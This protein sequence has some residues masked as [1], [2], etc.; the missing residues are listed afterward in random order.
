MVAPIPNPCSP[1]HPTTMKNPKASSSGKGSSQKAPSSSGAAAAPPPPPATANLG[2]APGP[3]SAAAAAAATPNPKEKPAAPTHVSGNLR[4][5]HSAGPPSTSPTPPPSRRPRLRTASTTSSAAPSCS[6][7]AASAPTSPSR[8]IRR[9][10]PPP[11]PPPI[12]CSPTAPN[13]PPRLRPRPGARRGVRVRPALSPPPGGRFSPEDHLRD[14][15]FGRGSG[16]QND[17]WAS[18]GLDG[19]RG[20]SESGP[21]SLKRKYGEDDELAWSRRHVLLYGGAGGNPPGLPPGWA[22]SEMISV[23]LDV[24]KQAL[25]RAF[26]KF[27]KTINESF[28]QKK[29][30]LENGK[31]EPLKCIACG[32][33]AYVWKFSFY[34]TTA[35]AM[36]A[37]GGA[38]PTLDGALVD[39]DG[40]LGTFGAMVAASTEAVKLIMP[41][42]LLIDSCFYGSCKANYAC[43]S[44]DWASK[45]FADVHALIM[46][47]YHSQ[48]Q[49]CVLIILDCTRHCGRPYF[50]A[51]IV[52]IHNTNLGRRKDGRMEGMGN[53]EMDN[54]LK[55]LG[56]P[57]GKSKSLILREGRTWPQRLSRA[58]ATLPSGDDDKNPLLVKLNERTGEKKRILYGYLAT[59]S[60]LDKVDF[61]M[62]KR[63]S[64]KSKREF[65]L[66][67]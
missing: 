36:H 18:L 49:T 4:S 24:D 40:S 22:G 27:S 33:F 1:S 39:I 52:I 67:D 26:L 21:S 59:A 23:P 55:D 17:Y 44:I 61:D 65:D 50:M 56:F 62:K 13:R 29:N 7:T 12:R 30:Y 41:T 15:R 63:A 19:P 66:S 51:T 64:V 28:S 6:P 5:P 31:N 45:D 32:R 20:P 9:R 46:H 25:K 57:G 16:P 48:M 35:I 53:K 14:P 42:F 8:R 37:L 34:L 38:V 58:Q 10:A 54:K 11:P 47:A 60:D 3:S 2:R 43:F